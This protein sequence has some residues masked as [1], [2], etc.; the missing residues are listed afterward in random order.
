MALLEAALS[1]TLSHLNVVQ[2]L[3]YRLLPLRP[4]EPRNAGSGERPAYGFSTDAAAAMTLLDGSSSSLSAPL[5][6]PLQSSSVT[7]IAISSTALSGAAL[8]APIRSEAGLPIS[9]F[10]QDQRKQGD[11]FSGCGMGSVMFGSS[12]DVH[13][14]EGVSGTTGHGIVGAHHI[15]GGI[16]GCGDRGCSGM[17]SSAPSGFEVQLI[18]E[19]CDGGS[20]R[21]ALDRRDFHHSRS[22]AL[23]PG[24]DDGGSCSGD[25]GGRGYVTA[26][27]QADPLDPRPDLQ[28]DLSDL[29]P[30]LQVV[31]SLAL[32]VARGMAHLHS[33][34]VVHAGKAL[35][36]GPQPM[37]DRLVHVSLRWGDAA[38]RPNSQQLP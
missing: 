5:P 38:L 17:A 7:S 35:V 3:S 23:M 29:Q 8:A 6:C 32:D 15:E 18:L 25:G 19:H 13:H 11:D 2:T 9:Q 12:M 36:D 4:S 37:P 14:F 10:G 24:G 31:L 30:D 33:S 21:E 16:D 20:L 1:S 34:N 26:D 22:E 28:L 27:T